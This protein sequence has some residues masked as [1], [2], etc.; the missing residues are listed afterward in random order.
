CRTRSTT[1]TNSTMIRR[2]FVE[3]RPGFD[4]EAS[5]LCQDL[6]ET[7]GIEALEGVRMLN[8][9]DVDDVTEEVFEQAVRL[10]FSEPQS[11]IVYLEDFTTK[12]A[13]TAFAVEYLPGQYD[14]RA[15]SAAQCIQ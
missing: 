5:Q 10:I 13:E 11:D 7:L 8:R 15:D 9:Y 6:R 14:Q 3:K 4:V 1:L 12:P 2:V